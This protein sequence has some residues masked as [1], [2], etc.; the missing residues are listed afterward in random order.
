M[1]IN[2]LYSEYNMNEFQWDNEKIWEWTWK[3]EK[4]I[5]SSVHKSNTYMRLTWHDKI[6]VSMA[7]LK[8]YDTTVCAKE[9][10]KKVFFLW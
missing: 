7:E 3:R 10:E 1:N 9:D 5:F 8:W 2:S 4:K 6:Y